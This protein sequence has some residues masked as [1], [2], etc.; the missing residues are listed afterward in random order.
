MNALKVAWISI[1]FCSTSFATSFKP[2]V[3]YDTAGKFDK[4]FNEAVYKGGVNLWW[5]N[6]VLK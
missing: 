3:I 4:S 5:K 6:M 1:I 2:A